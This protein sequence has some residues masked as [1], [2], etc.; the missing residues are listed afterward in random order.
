MKIRFIRRATRAG[1]TLIEMLIVVSIIGILSAIAIPLFSKQQLRTKSTEAKTNLSAIRVAQQSNFSELGLYQAASAEPVVIPGTQPTDFD[2]AGS[3]YAEIGWAP[4]GRVYFSYA[5]TITPDASGFTADAAADIDGD[6]FH[7][8]WGY[9]K[10]SG[11]GVLE[12]GGLGCDPNQLIP[13]I[14]GSCLLDSSIF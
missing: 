5:V 11:T 13:E 6:G 4:E 3:D 14:V 1:F 12:P 8:I 2:V 10:P 7:Q 9:T